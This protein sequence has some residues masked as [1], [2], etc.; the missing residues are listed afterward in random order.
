PS[1]PPSSPCPRSTPPLAPGG[2]PPPPSPPAG[3]S[4]PASPPSP[5]RALCGPSATSS[6]NGARP[7]F[8]RPGQLHRR[9]PE[10]RPTGGTGD[11]TISGMESSRDWSVHLRELFDE[12]GEGE[13]RRLDADARSRAS[14]EI[15]RRFLARF[16]SPGMRVLEVGAGPG[17]FT[18]ELAKLG[19][20]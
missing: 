15:H 4:S 2:G 7:T 16:L 14:L 20:R 3:S 5:S 13:W 18:V 1:E 19:C 9:D 17:R 6:G 10:I 11:A 8:R 12:V